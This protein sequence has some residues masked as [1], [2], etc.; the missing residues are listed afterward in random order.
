MT[1]FRGS[2]T[3]TIKRRSATATD[4]YGN[5]TYSTATITIK[6]AMIGFGG[7]SEGLEPDREPSDVSLTLYLPNGTQVLP[8]DRFIVRGTEF[9]KD[10]EAQSWSAP[11][12]FNVGVV[13]KVKR[14]N[15]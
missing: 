3:V 11:F 7:E 14:R 5:K 13:V 6:N 9:V 12:D 15:G 2:E 8:G 10:G 1:F 4:E